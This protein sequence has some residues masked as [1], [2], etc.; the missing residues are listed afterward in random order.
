MRQSAMEFHTG[1]KKYRGDSAVEI[2]RTLERDAFDYPYRGGTLWQFLLWSLLKQIP[3]GIPLSELGLS[4]RLNEETL[5]LGY[6]F[7]CE[8]YGLGKVSG[9]AE[10]V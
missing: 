7:L 5:A 10:R 2:V 4:E 6:L 3:D 8:Q 1:G 9:I